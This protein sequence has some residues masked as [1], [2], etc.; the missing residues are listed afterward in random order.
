MTRPEDLWGEDFAQKRKMIV[1]KKIQA[2]TQVTPAMRREI[3]GMCKTAFT[4]GRQAFDY[5]CGQ[6]TYNVLLVKAPN[7]MNPFKFESGDFSLKVD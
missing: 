7:E 6:S 2:R 3:I 4:G 1:A 5:P